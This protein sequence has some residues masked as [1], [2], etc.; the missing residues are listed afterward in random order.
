MAFYGNFGHSSNEV[1]IQIFHVFSRDFVI[2]DHGIS[3][4]SQTLLIP[5]PL[6]LPIPN[7]HEKQKNTQNLARFKTLSFIEARTF[8]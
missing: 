3:S 1:Y 6:A 5:S 4:I 7:S 2:L 8:C